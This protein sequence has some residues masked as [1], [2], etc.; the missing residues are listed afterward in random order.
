VVKAGIG[1]GDQRPEVRNEPVLSATRPEDSGGEMY[2]NGTI[3][4]VLKLP[5]TGVTQI[6]RVVP[7]KDY[8]TILYPRSSSS[9]SAAR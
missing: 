3:L 5:G 7:V 2:S 6:E 1:G 9:R 8:R 4:V